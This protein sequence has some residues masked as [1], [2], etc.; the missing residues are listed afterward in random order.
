MGHIVV[1]DP[2]RV[3]LSNLQ[4]QI[5]FGARDVGALKARVLADRMAAINPDIVAGARQRR[6]DSGNARRL[7]A[8]FDVILD[9]TDSFAAR[10]AVN[11]GAL[12]HGT[13]LVSGAVG[14]WDGQ[15]GV[16]GRPGPCYRCFVADAPPE[17]KNCDNGVIGALTGVVGSVMA[18]EAIKVLTG[19][20]DT[21][22][23]RLWL[24]GGLTGDSRTVRLQRDPDCAACA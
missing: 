13:P 6:V 11:A 12:H 10:F 23:G 8:G 3:E 19:A 14:R 1:M 15:V 24:Y 9:G 22:A 5:Q 16:F 17:A 20:G 2:D 21:L 18:L 4:R 7:L